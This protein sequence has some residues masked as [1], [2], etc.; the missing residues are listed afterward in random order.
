MKALAALFILWTLSVHNPLKVSLGGMKWS[1]VREGNELI[2]ELSAPTKGWVAVGFNDENNILHSDLIMFRVVDGQVEVQDM[3][4]K[5]VGDPRLDDSLG[6]RQ[7]ID[8]LEAEERDQQTYVRFRRPW[9]GKDDYD[10]NLEQGE[11]FWLILAYS[12]HDDFAHHSRLRR[13]VKVI[14]N[15]E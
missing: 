4:V 6:G 14:F 13:H 2:M 12:T 9:S 11:T 10:Y 7:N 3:Y 1:C 8:M 5:G 15:I